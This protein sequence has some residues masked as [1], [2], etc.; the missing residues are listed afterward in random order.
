[1]WDKRIVKYCSIVVI[2]ELSLLLSLFFLDSA[3]GDDR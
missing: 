3:G 2:V 1:M